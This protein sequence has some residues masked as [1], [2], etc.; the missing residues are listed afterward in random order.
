MIKCY[1]CKHYRELFDRLGGLGDYCLLSTIEEL[2]V[3]PVNGNRLVE[4]MDYEGCKK[5]NYND[6]PY[7]ERDAWIKSRW[8]RFWVFMRC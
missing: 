2:K 4:Y 6:C 8:R 3:D 7:F 5:N 1:D